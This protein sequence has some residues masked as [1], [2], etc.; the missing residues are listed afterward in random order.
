MSSAVALP[1]SASAAAFPQ[2][3]VRFDKRRIFTFIV[4]VFGMF[5]AILDIQI[6]S[7]SLAEIQAG[8]S[9]SA[10]EITWVQTSYLVAEVVMIPLSGY[11]S[12]ALSTRVLFS[13]SAGGFTL[14]SLMCAH[15]GSIE[16][17]IVW[18]ALQGFIGGAM[19]PTV[20][21]TAF[22]IFPPEKRSIVSPV[23]GLV[24]TLAPTIGPTCG[25]YLTDLF[26]WHWL[27]LINILPGIFVTVVT[28][29]MID[30]D[31]PD[32]SLL[33]KFDFVGLLSLAA[34]LGALEYVLEEGPNK[35]WFEEDVIV[36]GTI[37]SIAG[38]LIFVWRAFSS[39]NPVVELR[40]RDRNFWSGCALSFTMGVGLYGL[41]YL[42]P[43][44]LARVRGFSALQIGETM[45]VSGAVMFLSAPLAG[46]LAA[47]VDARIIIGLGFLSFGAGAWL[48]SDIT[49]DWDFGELILPQVFR[50]A[51]LMFAMV[52]INSVALGGLPQK[53]LKNA[54]GLFNLTRNL[55]G[56]VGL[57]IINT[58][59]NDRMDL[60]LARL[61]ERVTWTSE[62][63]QDM[64]SSLTGAFASRGSDAGVA[65][66]KQMA[67]LVRREALVMAMGDVFV[68]LAILFAVMVCVLP[69]VRKPPM[70]GAVPPELRNKLGLAIS[71]RT[72]KAYR[73]LLASA[74]WQKLAAAGARAARFDGRG[75]LLM[76]CIADVHDAAAREQM[77][78]SRMP[79]RHHAVEHVDAAPHR[80]DDV[81]RP[82]H[83]HQVARLCRGHL[84]QQGLEDRFALRFGLAD[85]ETADG[86]T[87]KTNV[88]E[89]RQ[90]F[91]AQR[92]I[93]AALH[94]AEQ[95]ARR[96][97]E[98]VLAKTARR[99]THR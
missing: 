94:D 91:A 72:Y 13:V 69:F 65:A 70:I 53:D 32:Y 96:F 86:Q 77:G 54:S 8:L 33:R 11:L 24:A 56:A 43:V 62:R 29:F 10:D 2:P 12:R 48:A 6:V 90:G 26:S 36:W 84:R 14:M 21:A 66:L 74:R 68:V 34:F 52:A 81:L 95:R 40:I 49:K 41:T 87:R 20:F 44:Y 37:V 67:A 22:T 17:M 35:N 85:G 60:H 80:F 45:F 64:L 78:V 15:A 59:L 55:G 19:I 27:F 39:A 5:M 88:L 1:R 18:R 31:T 63:A 16:E 76:R 92:G 89:R 75:V 9:A 50:G 42:Y 98:V 79:G 3:A 30:F 38:A 58:M 71:G 97:G 4:M 51:G 7:A 83:A 99:P 23:I 82:A 73:D 28:W 47:K 61:H 25:G 57:A 93:D 46:R